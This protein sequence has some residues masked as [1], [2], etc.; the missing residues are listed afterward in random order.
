ML[1]IMKTHSSTSL[2]NV[3]VSVLFQKSHV[4]KN[5]GH[6]QSSW[7]FYFCK[8]N[9]FLI[10]LRVCSK[11]KFRK[12]LHIWI[13]LNINPTRYMIAITLSAICLFQTRFYVVVFFFFL[14]IHFFPMKSGT[15]PRC[16]YRDEIDWWLEN[17]F[18]AI[19]RRFY[20]I[21]K[22]F[23]HKE[24]NFSVRIKEDCDWLYQLIF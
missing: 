10:D 24:E 1:L 9:Q 21:S 17:K 15:S 23:I 2:A 8:W 7:Q 19:D 12:Y 6:W 4:I 20:R 5:W 13:A 22:T 16:Q 3:R 11:W 18:V 14:L